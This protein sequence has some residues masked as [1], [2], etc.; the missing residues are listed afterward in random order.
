ML[1]FTFD[2]TYFN[3]GWAIRFDTEIMIKL[4]KVIT[5]HGKKLLDSKHLELVA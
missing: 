5:A 1:E 3:L 2:P 4:H